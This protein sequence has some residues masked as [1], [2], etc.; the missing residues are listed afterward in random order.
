MNR[1][2]IRVIAPLAVLSFAAAAC[3]DDDTAS[4]T[5]Q[6]SGA[7]TATT[8]A[9][10]MTDDAMAPSGAGAGASGA[11][12]SSATICDAD[13]LVAAVEGGPSEGTLAGMTDDPVATAASSNPVL[14]TLVSA[15]GAAGLGDTL[16]SADELTVFAPT[17]CA[18]AALDPATLQAALDDPQG[19][20]TQVL[21]F[22]VVPQRLS[23]DDLAGVSELETFTGE[24]LAISADG[25]AIELAGGQARIVVPDIQTANATVYL[26]DHVMVPGA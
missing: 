24:T 11:A 3:G 18:F 16:N 10:P 9:E 6:V 26:I 20:L 21:G 14:T 7:P 4:P 22:H 25:D 13:G 17:D 19:L 5:D 15:V 23:S 8:A 2:L 12:G 1:N